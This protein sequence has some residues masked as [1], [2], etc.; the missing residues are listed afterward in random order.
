[1]D[2]SRHLLTQDHLVLFSSSQRATYDAILSRE[3]FRAAFADEQEW[4]AFLASFMSLG[5]FNKY[6]PVFHMALCGFMHNC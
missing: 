2:V 3:D 5:F 4:A 6:V 1:M